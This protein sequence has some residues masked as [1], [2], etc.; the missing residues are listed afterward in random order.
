VAIGLFLLFFLL[1][2]RRSV[3]H[4][5]DEVVAG[6]DLAQITPITASV[7]ILKLHQSQSL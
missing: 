7:N 6:L 2:L 3:D 4:L 5:A 1:P